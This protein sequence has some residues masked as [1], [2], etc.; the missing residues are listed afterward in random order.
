MSKIER[1]IANRLA[2]GSAPGRA[3]ANPGRR[4]RK[5]RRKTG[6]RAPGTPNVMTREVKEAIIEGLSR[7]GWQGQGCNRRL[8]RAHWAGGH[9]VGRYVAAR[10]TAA[11]G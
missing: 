8:C 10:N 6:G 5:G 2:K 11:A 1:K 7:I 9:P 3:R 4:Y